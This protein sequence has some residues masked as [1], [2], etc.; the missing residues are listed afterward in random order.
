MVRPWPLHRGSFSF[1]HGGRSAPPRGGASLASAQYRWRKRFERKLMLAPR[2]S[3]RARTRP[4]PM[5][6]RDVAAAFTARVSMQS[7]RQLPVI[8]VQ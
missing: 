4:G 5:Q 7:F 8:N 6:F 1:D 2:W 3:F